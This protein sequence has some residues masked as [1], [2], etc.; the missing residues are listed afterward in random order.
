MR[1][2]VG[3]MEPDIGHDQDDFIKNNKTIRCTVEI[4]ISDVKSRDAE[5][6]ARDMTAKLRRWAKKHNEKREKLSDHE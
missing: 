1:T 4:Y 5:K 3:I 2:Y 6:V